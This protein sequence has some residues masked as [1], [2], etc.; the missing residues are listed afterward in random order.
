MDYPLQA[1]LLLASHFLLTTDGIRVTSAEFAKPGDICLWEAC[2]GINSGLRVPLSPQHLITPVSNSSPLLDSQISKVSSLCP[3]T[4][5]IK[6]TNNGTLTTVDKKPFQIPSSHPRI[7]VGLVMWTSSNNRPPVTPMRPCIAE[8]VIITQSLSFAD[9]TRDHKLRTRTTLTSV[10]VMPITQA[11]AT[12]IPQNR[13]KAPVRVRFLPNALIT[14]TLKPPRIQLGC[15]RILHTS[16]WHPTI[17]RM[18]LVPSETGFQS[19]ILVTNRNL[20]II[21]TAASPPPR[22]TDSPTRARIQ[23][24]L[25]LMPQL[26]VLS[27]IVRKC[28]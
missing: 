23:K 21:L 16:A 24:A 27:T 2:S 4:V 11:P 7:V 5:T 13:T 19:R 22:H 9:P 8:P 20:D 1:F 18:D 26:L 10:T 6:A 3:M 25:L 28:A 12:L 14:V 15:L 17:S